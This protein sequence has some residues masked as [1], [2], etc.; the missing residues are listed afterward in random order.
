[1]WIAPPLGPSTVRDVFHEIVRTREIGHSNSQKK[2]LKNILNRLREGFL[3]LVDFV[4]SLPPNSVTETLKTK[5][6]SVQG[7]FPY[8]FSDLV[9]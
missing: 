9:T 7:T 2:I 4:A 8:A 5:T 3:L 1:M 6:L